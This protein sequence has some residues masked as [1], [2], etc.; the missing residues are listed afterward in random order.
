M[1][2]IHP[3]VAAIVPPNPRADQRLSD[4]RIAVR[5]CARKCGD[6][7]IEFIA[8]DRPFI[9]AMALARTG[10]AIDTGECCHPGYSYIPEDKLVLVAAWLRREF[11]DTKERWLAQPTGTPYWYEPSHDHVARLFGLTPKDQ[12]FGD[13]LVADLTM[14]GY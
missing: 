2:F 13:Q 9:V 12:E 1:F 8:K 11:A 10:L 7:A 4:A 5:D 3:E 14:E 6:A